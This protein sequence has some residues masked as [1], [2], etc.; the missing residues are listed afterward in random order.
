MLRPSLF[1]AF[2]PLCL[3]D[4]SVPLHLTKGKPLNVIG[5]FLTTILYEE[6]FVLS[7]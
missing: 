1:R 6:T 4:T 5:D 3:P 7:G 2:A